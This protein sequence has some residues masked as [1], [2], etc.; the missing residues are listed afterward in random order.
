[1]LIDILEYIL[2]FTIIA[3]C[4]SL[5][6]F[7]ENYRQ[8][9][10]STVFLFLTIGLIGILLA[11]YSH[12][13]VE[14]IK[15][16]FRR[17]LPFFA[18]LY[19]AILA[20]G[21]INVR[22]YGGYAQIREYV[23]Y[24]CILLPLLC[25][26]F[27][28]QRNA[29]KPYVLFLKH[30]DIICG[31][32]AIN[33]V[34]Y[35]TVI[36]HP[37]ITWANITLSRWSNLGYL[38]SFHNFLNCCNVEL[39]QI[40]DIM[41]FSVYRNQG[42]FPEPLMFVIPLLTALSTEMYLRKKGERK[43][44]KWC[45]LSF[46]VI[47]TQAT[48]G[49]MLLIALCGVKVLAASDT[50]NR[51]RMMLPVM[52]FVVGACTLLFVQKSELSGDS[53]FSSLAV[54]IED[55]KLAF[56][57][58]LQ[59]PFIG[60][61]YQNEGAIRAFMTQ[62]RIT[63]NTGLSNSVA[64]ILAEG[65]I[66]LGMICMFPFAVCF[67]QIRKGQNKELALWAL[68]PFGLYCLTTF[69][70]HMFLMLLM[71]F[72]YG[73]VEIVPS[74]N[75][76]WWSLSIAD[77][78]QIAE[79]DN[80]RHE[81]PKT[82]RNV[83]VFL[84]C[85]TTVLLLIS[86]GFWK[87]LYGI[88][89]KNQLYLGQSAW[90]CYFFSLLLIVLVYMI[91]SAVNNYKSR[92]MTYYFVWYGLCI[93]IYVFCYPM[94][95]SWVSTF[96]ENQF[97]TGDLVESFILG[98]ILICGIIYGWG[99]I[100]YYLDRKT[101]IAVKKRWI[102]ASLT[103]LVVVTILSFINSLNKRIQDDISLPTQLTSAIDQALS[104]TSGILY[105]NDLPVLLKHDIPQIKYCASRDGAFASY[106]T[107]SVISKHSRNLRDLIE[108]GFQVA[109]LSQDYLL[110]SNDEKLIQGMEKHGYTFY[111]YFA[112]EQ[113]VNLQKLS[114][115]NW[116]IYAGGEVRIEGEDES[117]QRGPY[118]E[119]KSGEYTLEYT[120]HR[121]PEEAPTHV[122]I[123][124][125][126]ILSYYGKN[127]IKN[128]EI[129]ED[130][131]DEH[132]DLTVKLTFTAGDWEGMEYLAVAEQDYAFQIRRIVL[133]E[134]P[135]Y[136]TQR[137][138]NGRHQVTREVYY[139]PSGQYYIQPQ[140]F[141]AIEK[142]YDRIGHIRTLRYFDENNAAVRIR[143]G[144]AR[145][146][147][148]YDKLGRVMRETY[149]D[150]KNQK[151]ML[152]QGYA[153]W[154][155]GYDSEG[156]VNIVKYFDSENKPVMLASGYAE[157]HKDF[158]LDRKVIRE[159]Y[160]DEKGNSIKLPSGYASCEYDYDDKGNLIVIRYLDEELQKVALSQNYAEVHREYNLNKQIIR[161][162]YYGID[163]N[164]VTVPQG[165]SIN[166]R[167]YDDAGNAVVQR[168][169]D[170]NGNLVL[171]TM[172]YAEVHRVFNEKHWIVQETYYDAKGNKHCIPQGY[173]LDKREYDNL[174]NV[175][176]QAFFDTE[177]QPVMTSNGYA[178]IHR[179]YNSNNQVILEWYF[180]SVGSPITMPQGY[181]YIEREYDEL[182]NIV[183][184]RYLNVDQKPVITSWGFA[185]EH[186]EF[187]EKR[188]MIRVCYYDD[189]GKAF[190]LESGQAGDIREYD[191][192]GRMISRKFFDIDDNPVML[193]L[194]Y[195]E[196]YLEYNEN[197]QIIRERYCD[198]D[199]DLALTNKG[200]AEIRRSFN[201]NGQLISEKYYDTEGLEIK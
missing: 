139:S 17:Y 97:Q 103:V 79:E 93:I 150:Q 138:Y 146:D 187:N 102:P 134:T 190:M 129:Y 157:V 136:V 183:I 178:E 39:V 110:Y 66:F 144:Y 116:T 151:C 50:P 34:V 159:S 199:G 11:L 124:T 91:H 12:K 33:L 84:G 75:K 143:A 16:S 87:L 62:E 131:F 14:D 83:L 94:L 24:F 81:L 128:R 118:D 123:G 68:A 4:N 174:G 95:Y 80:V 82:A 92:S 43:L 61:G 148:D 161:E 45:V 104:E 114:A 73:L 133:K 65:G 32:A 1:M 23:L 25:F 86:E 10:V 191:S 98:A 126:S 54:H 27:R 2:T 167:E 28:V 64:V 125:L 192:K 200:Y 15:N 100:W 163:G 78:P 18:V 70:F 153:S 171:T 117:I 47:S 22:V 21:A 96:A 121:T 26:L 188:E 170:I 101:E 55:Y 107:V 137:V 44:W 193:T 166:E 181:A 8:A 156:N 7:S 59:H 182:G 140:G 30:S 19:A 195:A 72:G 173:W 142:E 5:F 162:S 58:F 35:L 154:S 175:T 196:I 198:L 132:G 135:Q 63:R 56:K 48:L 111:K 90:K 112:F 85:V 46:V 88:L 29:G 99:I 119:L 177:E 145:V 3:E 37:G 9:P 31:V 130:E 172:N 113:P 176:I 36:L 109:E 53:A 38:R 127:N 168:Y 164:L 6:V 152:P 115:Y 71:A 149:Y 76:G 120:L 74:K 41:G 89:K 201:E 155:Q 69:H 108:Q 122:K 158:N 141:A 185:E 186:R 57:A 197:N 106:K 165:Y 184:Q 77:G 189:N 67:S 42:F 51:K 40:R 20:F 13:S 52:A 180:D 169:Y 194:G 105:A 160:Y 147:R 60:N 49:I 179:D